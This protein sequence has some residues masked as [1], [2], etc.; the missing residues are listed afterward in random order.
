M[1]WS[2]SKIVGLVIVPMLVAST[3]LGAYQSIRSGP[4]ETGK[5]DTLTTL[6]KEARHMIVGIDEQNNVVDQEI[7]EEQFR[8][9]VIY[10][11]ISAVNC[12]LLYFIHAQDGEGN[13][14]SEYIAGNSRPSKLSQD[15]TGGGGSKMIKYS[16]PGRDH[17]GDG[18]GDRDN[19]LFNY[20][21][22]ST[23]VPTCL[24]TANTIS[25]HMVDRR[26]QAVRE[27]DLLGA[28]WEVGVG[29][30]VGGLTDLWNAATCKIAPGWA[31]GRGN[32]M[33]GK[34]GKIT[35]E[36]RQNLT[37]SENEIWGV[38]ALWDENNC[39]AGNE[40]FH[41][42]T[43][44]AGGEW[45]NYVPYPDGS[46]TPKQENYHINGK[47]VPFGET[48]SASMDAIIDAP[49]V[50]TKNM[51][52]T[53]GGGGDDFPVGDVTYVICDGAEGYVQTNAQNMTNTGE[54]IWGPS[55]YNNAGEYEGY[56]TKTFTFVRVERGAKRCFNEDVM[57]ESGTL[58]D[59]NEI[60]GKYCNSF[61][62]TME[63]RTTDDGEVCGM[64]KY[65]WHTSADNLLAEV[66]QIG[67][68][69]P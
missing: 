16:I 63:T 68:I 59:S 60:D 50:T 45:M 26:T 22:E 54:A 24:G 6:R 10:S 55:P 46:T 39:P 51:S 9:L 12:K 4:L 19:S 53:R 11:Q 49:I 35:F 31:K 32:D 38:N 28:A 20:L 25:H 21:A 67:W 47:S 58:L 23:Y 36:S 62:D 2:L 17:D 1:S 18:P 37:L 44:W 5:E 56:S 14:A 43:F 27:G 30:V 52:G 41:G 34:Y 33:E 15:I 8:E 7:A 66:W 13:K 48:K 3:I 40:N 42:P 64:K 69:D 57:Y 29:T 65:S 61:E